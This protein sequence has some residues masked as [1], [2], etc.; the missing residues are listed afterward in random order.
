MQGT[1]WASHCISRATLALGV[2]P[3]LLVSPLRA[4]TPEQ[5][6]ALDAYRDSLLNVQD[7]SALAAEEA[8]LVAAARK[9]R[10]DAFVHLRLGHLELRQ[11][12]LSGPSHYNDAASEFK[13]GTEIAPQWP[14]AWYGLG[15][16]ELALGTRGDEVGS[17]MLAKSAWSRASEAFARAAALEPGFAPRIEEMARQALRAGTPERASVLRSAL[18]G[19]VRQA[20]PGR[21]GRLLLGLARIQREMGDS[22]A[23]DTFESYLYSGD[24]RGL[25][26]LEMGRARLLAGDLGG[27]GDYLE[28]LASDD[29]IAVAEARTDFSALATDAELA[30][31]DFRRGSSRADMVRRFWNGRDRVE[32]RP[33]GARL[34]EHLRRLRIARKEFV[35]LGADGVE[36]LDDRGRVFIRHGEPDDRASFAIPGVEPN[37][38]WRYRRAG[39]DMLLHFTA[40]QAPKDFRLIESVLDVSDVRYG[41]GNEPSGV[42]GPSP[43]DEQL[44]RSRSALSP[45]YRQVVGTRPEQFADYVSRERAAGRRGIQMATRTD[46]YSLR[47]GQELDAWGEYVVAGGSASAPEVQVI[48]AIP[49][50]NVEPATGAAGIVYPVRV[51]FIALDSAGAVVAAVD[52]VTRIEP[53]DRVAANRSLMGRIAVPVRPGRLM[54]Q[55]AVYYGEIAGSAF[56]VDT[57]DVPSPG[58]GVL[59][60]SDVLIGTRRGKL[61]MDVGG[62][63]FAIA[64]AGAVH[65]SDGAE[66][67]VEVFGLSPTERAALEV[68]I[69]PRDSFSPPP[70]P[71]AQWRPFPDDRAT[72][73]IG[74]SQ[75]GDPIARWRGSLS[76]SRLKPGSWWLAVIVTDSAGRQVR[77]VAPL[78]VLLP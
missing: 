37:E 76:L 2:V 58:A 65:R 51:R 78:E 43:S 74:R 22:S 13:W 62:P 15:T 48:F 32:L 18:S 1:R 67:A 63:D 75:W 60:L 23:L 41:T 55:A 49:G 72:E 27:A 39:A 10:S 20:V 45:L 40:H 33:E 17:Q 77:R 12:E 50:Y 26:L 25:A 69:A 8:R 19:A 53:G 44:L 66:V 64:P 6:R 54:V 7:S 9:S 35:I 71:A 31:F 28:G 36:R 68:Q 34:A 56:G 16:A 38:S 5:R 52:T 61:M 4:Q 73:H 24:N 59:A 47:F 21:E 3:C 14:Y 70:V 42:S 11:A 30:D 57:V 46:N 29:P